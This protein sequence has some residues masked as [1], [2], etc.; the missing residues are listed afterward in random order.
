MRFFFC[1]LFLA[2]VARGEDPSDSPPSETPLGHSYHGEVFNEGPRQAA[3]LIDGTG[4]VHFS[5]TT[6]SQKAQQFFDQGIGQ[7]HGFWDFEAERSFRQVAAIDPDCAMAYWGMA[8]ANFSND[9]RGSGFAEEAKERR[10]S[11][12]EREQLWIDGLSDYFA[13][14]KK[15]KKKRLREWVRAIEEIASLYPDDIE[16]KAFLMKQIYYNHNRGL[17]IPSHYAINLLIDEVLAKDPDHPVHHYRIHLWDYEDPEKALAAAAACGPSA[18]AIAHMW[19][20]PGHT[21]SRLDRYA[22]A[23]YQQEA[24]AR[25]DHAH[26]MRFQIVPD[27]I[28]NFAHNNE[29]CIRNLDA[30]GQHT[31]AVD[32][33]FNMISLPRLAKFKEVDGEEVYDPKGSSWAWGRKRLR[34]TLFKFEQWSDL[35]AL[36]DSGVLSAD[37]KSIEQDEV[38]RYVGIARFESGDWDG[39]RYHL[40]ELEGRLEEKIDQRDEA[41]AAASKKATDEGKDAEAVEAAEKEA[42]K[43][44]QSDITA[45]ERLVSELSVYAELSA[46]SPD[47]EAARE[48]LGD[49]AKF[50]KARLAQLWQRAGGEEKAIELSAEAVKDGGGEVLPLA[51]RVEVLYD[52]GKLDQAAEAFESLRETAY[53]SDLSTPPLSRLSSIAEE[54]GLPKD[55]RRA[56]TPPGDIGKRPPLDSLGPFRWTA[57]RAPVFDLVN[58]D[59]DRS[60]LEDFAGRRV[61]MLFYLGTECEHCIEQLAAFEAVRKDWNAVGI[62]LVAVSTDG[63]GKVPEGIGLPILF[64]PDLETFRSFRAYDDFEEMAL[65]GTFLIDELGSIRWKDI[66]HEPFMRHEW[67]L[68]ESLRLLELESF[69]S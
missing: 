6:E 46:E 53:L 49:V 20:M 45:L 69:G 57:P 41:V 27:R 64:D 14:K 32:L 38:D 5:V 60:S 8:M 28:S 29:W 10:E 17:P 47:L 13:D 67:L 39:G 54:L 61:L 21:Y 31:R 50:S 58:S 34:D 4:D 59:G 51:A 48:H 22:D 9:E 62:E 68:E 3:V 55:W 35:I 33:A 12:S 63:S 52:Q 37:G 19:H 42:K 66:G 36:T 26:M 11:V 25:I 40:G 23:V 44:Y 1:L 65:H 30:T 15:E 56:P 18:P 2:V 24:S 16:A 43:K 7:L